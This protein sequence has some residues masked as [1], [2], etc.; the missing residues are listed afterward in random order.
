MLSI[1][2]CDLSLFSLTTLLLQLSLTTLPLQLCLT[3]LPLQLYT[4]GNSFINVSGTE[5]RSRWSRGL[6]RESAAAHLLGLRVRILQGHGCLSFGSAVSCQ[7]EVSTSDWALVHRSPTESGVSECDR[8]ALIMRRPW[9]PGEL[10]R[11]GKKKNSGT[12]LS[13]D[14]AWFYLHG[15]FFMLHQ[16]VQL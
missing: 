5:C 9:P 11:F 12:E 13:N 1:T 16:E 2:T 10:L 14:R 3:T 8:E 15:N 7:V 4:Y 6:R